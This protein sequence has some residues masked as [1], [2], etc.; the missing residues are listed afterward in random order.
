MKDLEMRDSNVY[1]EVILEMG[2]FERDTAGRGYVFMGGGAVGFCGTLAIGSQIDNVAARMDM[3]SGYAESSD[4]P[5]PSTPE[6]ALMLSP[7]VVVPL[8]M[9]SIYTRV[10]HKKYKRNVQEKVQRRI[11]KIVFEFGETLDRELSTTSHPFED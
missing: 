2:G 3:K 7:I 1:Q 10:R 4:A 6:M 5:S 11:N 9:A 8:I